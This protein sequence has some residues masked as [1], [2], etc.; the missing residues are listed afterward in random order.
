MKRVHYAWVICAAGTLTMICNMGLCCTLLSAYLPYIVAEGISGS[1]GSMILSARS[2]ATLAAMFIVGPYYKRV[3]LRTGITLSLLLAS[4]AMLIFSVGGS[5]PVYILAAAVAGMAFGL[6]GAI[7]LPILIRAWFDGRRG[8]A[9]GIVSAGSGVANICFPLV[10]ERLVA[11]FGLRGMFWCAAG[12]VVLSALTV[13]L[14]VRNSPEEMALAPYEGGGGKAVKKAVPGNWELPP[15]GWVLLVLLMVFQGGYS[16]SVS[17]LS[18]TMTGSGYSMEQAALIFSFYGVAI[19]VGK[20]LYG[21][22]SDRIG[23]R[24][25]AAISYALGIAA[26]LMPLLM[27]GRMLWPCA[28]TALLLGVGTPPNSVGIAIVAAEISSPRTYANTI[29]CMEITSIMGSAAM[30]LVPGVFFDRTGSYLGAYMLMAVWA[31]ACLPLLWLLSRS[32]RPL[33]ADGGGAVPASPA[34][35]DG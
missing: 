34:G 3:S 15:V 28:A 31:A 26:C 21:A 17:H 11:A 8:T 24:R 32:R 35:R 33:R 1:A 9:L 27:D 30:G 19:T 22:A 10:I 5:A 23:A 20:I 29:L 16:P 6:G 18:V 25:T 13:W 12:F 2:M 7:P 14:L 4:A